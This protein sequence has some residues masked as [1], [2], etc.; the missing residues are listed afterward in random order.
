MHTRTHTSDVYQLNI[1]RTQL[2]DK[3]ANERFDHLPSGDLPRNH[4]EIFTKELVGY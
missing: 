1:N 4:L 3:G 2:E